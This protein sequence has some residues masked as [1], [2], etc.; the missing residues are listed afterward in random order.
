MESPALR[1]GLGESKMPTSVIF[2][3]G[4]NKRSCRLHKRTWLFYCFI[5]FFSYV[6]D[7]DNM[8]DISRLTPTDLNMC[9]SILVGNT[10]NR[11][12][13][14]FPTNNQCLSTLK[15][16]SLSLCLYTLSVSWRWLHF[17]GL[18]RAMEY[19]VD[20]LLHLESHE[21]FAGNNAFDP[22]LE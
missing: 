2:F 15:R 11:R 8:Q 17:L 20:P 13:I 6:C 1:V 14:N 22:T 10:Q 7:F 5:F 12:S 18:G 21:V 19:T 4:K 16:I 3:L 9:Y